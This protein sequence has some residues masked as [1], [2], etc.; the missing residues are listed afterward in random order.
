MG[1]YGPKSK[2]VQRNKTDEEPN[3]KGLECHNKLNKEV[4]AETHSRRL[5]PNM[6][7]PRRVGFWVRQSTLRRILN[8]SK[9][10][11]LKELG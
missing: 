4:G 10:P 1:N 6:V 7:Q 3:E 5:A 2:I 9:N 8:R 11:I